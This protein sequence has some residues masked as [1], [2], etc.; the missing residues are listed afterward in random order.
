MPINVIEIFNLEDYIVKFKNN[1]EEILSNYT[2]KEFKELIKACNDEK[3]VANLRT[4]LAELFLE[5]YNIRLG[6][7]QLKNRKG[8]KILESYAE[9]IYSL[10]TFYLDKQ[11]SE[12]INEIFSVNIKPGDFI[13]EKKRTE[14]LINQLYGAVEIN[15]KKPEKMASIDDSIKTIL[16]KLDNLNNKYSKVLEN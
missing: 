4:S 3:K 10:S 7:I 5:N 2:R 1:I 9:D 13:R 12:T 14:I 6:E 11:F 15:R 8:Q 16:M